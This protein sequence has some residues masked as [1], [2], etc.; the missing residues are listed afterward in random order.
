MASVSD[1]AAVAVAW[2]D[3][4][5]GYDVGV[6]GFL[7]ADNLT[8]RG[9]RDQSD[10]HAMVEAGCLRLTEGNVIDQE[11]ILAHVVELAKPFRI[12]E[13]ILDRWGPPGS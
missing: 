4:A 13:A 1:I 2:P 11:A 10:D 7:P 8:A 6:T 9:E 5:G 12:E 3:G